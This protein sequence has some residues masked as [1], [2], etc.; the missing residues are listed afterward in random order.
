MRAL[1]AWRL[2]CFMS[3][4]EGRV[5]FEDLPGEGVIARNDR[6]WRGECPSPLPGEDVFVITA[7]RPFSP[8][9]QPLNGHCSRRQRPAPICHAGGMQGT[10]FGGGPT[11]LSPQVVLGPPAR[12]AGGNLHAYKSATR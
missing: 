12:P 9:K 8:T 5:F 4:E 3:E 10:P 1:V 6:G 2:E 7:T 11:S